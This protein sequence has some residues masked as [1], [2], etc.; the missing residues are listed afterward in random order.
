MLN[1]F[2]NL[3]CV[4]T[5]NPAKRYAFDNCNLRR[6]PGDNAHMNIGY[7]YMEFTNP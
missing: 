3:N 6:G 7:L 5:V 4:Y 2:N 1:V